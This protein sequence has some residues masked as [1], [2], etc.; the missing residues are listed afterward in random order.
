[1]S[2]IN[3]DRAEDEGEISEPGMHPEDPGGFDDWRM[4]FC[5]SGCRVNTAQLV[6]LH[7]CYD[8]ECRGCVARCL[9]CERRDDR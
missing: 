7:P 1:M 5:E 3:L 9:S 2:A 8:P 6:R 4:G